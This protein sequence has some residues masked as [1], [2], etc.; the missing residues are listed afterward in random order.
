MQKP[1]LAIAMPMLCACGAFYHCEDWSFVQATG[2]LSVGAPQHVNDNWI[3]PVIANV[4][5]TQ[6]ITTNPTVINSGMVCRSVNADIRKQSIYLTIVT[7]VAGDS[8]SA[9][10]PPASLRHISNGKY[11]VYYRN[12]NDTSIALGEVT[13]GP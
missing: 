6:T 9:I 12:H 11:A 4:S 3:L 1:I 8:L 5:G 10:C 7:S 13:I 2:G